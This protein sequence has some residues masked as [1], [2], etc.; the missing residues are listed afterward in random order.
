MA[1]DRIG[2]SFASPT[3]DAMDIGPRS[4]YGRAL[5]DPSTQMGVGNIGPTQADAAI[6]G[7]MLRE[8]A[9]LKR[10]PAGTDVAGSAAPEPLA[11]SGGMASIPYSPSTQKFWIGGRLVDATN[12]LEV[13]ASEPLAGRPSA[14]APSEVA[15][16]WIGLSPQAYGQYVSK[17]KTPRGF[18]ANVALGARGL[19]EQTLGGVGDILS[20]VGAPSVGEPIAKFAETTFGQTKAEQE[21]SA[22]IQQSNSMMSNIWDAVAQG[23]PSVGLSFVGGGLGALA[24]AARATRIAGAAANLGQARTIGALTGLAAVTYPS[25][26]QNFYE[27]A[28]NAKNPDGTPAYNLNDPLIGA[29]IAAAAG[30]TTLLQTFA[31]GKIAAGF[32]PFFTD[33]IKNA[34][35]QVTRSAIGRAAVGGA[36]GAAS[37]A[38]AEGVTQ[39]AQQAVFDPEFRSKL[40]ASDWKALA[41]YVIEKY[42]ENALIA[43]GAGAVLGG[44]FG[45][46]FGTKPAVGLGNKPTNLLETAGG[47]KGPAP[48]PTQMELPL[49]GPQ[50]PQLELP[51]EMPR[52]PVPPSPEPTAPAAP[53]PGQMELPLG[54]PTQLE[55][56]LTMPQ[57]DTTGLPLFEF[58]QG[59]LQTP[60]GGQIPLPLEGGRGVAPTP[61]T[62]PVTPTQL[63]LPLDMPQPGLPLEGGVARLR[64][65]QPAIGRQLQ[66]Q[67]AASLAALAARSEAAKA[68][69]YPVETPTFEEAPTVDYLKKLR[70]FYAAEQRDRVRLQ[71][72]MKASAKRELAN[73]IKAK[74]ITKAEAKRL[75]SNH[76]KAGNDL[77]KQLD[78][79]IADPTTIPVAGVTP[80]APAPAAA[81]VQPTEIPNAPQ[82]R[83]VPEGGVGQY[84]GTSGQVQGEGD[85]RNVPTQVQEGGDQTGGGN[86]PVEGGPQPEQVEP[87]TT[88]TK[89]GNVTF[90]T[91]IDPRIADTFAALWQA[92]G[93]ADTPVFF[94]VVNDENVKA[95]TRSTPEALG[96]STAQHGKF[97]T[98]LANMNRS[99]A[100]GNNTLLSDGTT[101]IF[102]KSEGTLDSRQYVRALETISHE[103]GHSVERVLLSKASNAEIA[104]IISDYNKFLTKLNVNKSV[105]NDIN[106]SIIRRLNALATMNFPATRQE[107]A[108]TAE[109]FKK[110]LA[111]AK[112]T[113][114]KDLATAL[115][116]SQ[117]AK[118]TVRGG[119][120]DTPFMQTTVKDKLDYWL[121]FNEWFADQTSKWATTQAKPLT[122]VEKF[123]KRLAD[124][125][126]RLYAAGRTAGLPEQSVSTFLDRMG[127][128]KFNE[129]IIPPPPPPG[130]GV[131]DKLVRDLEPKLSEDVVTQITP[132]ENAAA[133]AR[134]DNFIE[135]TVPAP[136][137]DMAYTI[138]YNI[139]D[140][141]LKGAYFMSFS[142]D[143]INWISPL[144]PT[145]RQYFDGIQK[146]NT[147]IEQLKREVDEVMKQTGDLGDAYKQVNQFLSD[148]TLRQAWGFQP[149]WIK[150]PVTIDPQMQAQYN[151][152]PDNAKKVVSAVFEKNYKD[153]RKMR[154][155]IEEQVRAGLTGPEYESLPQ[156]EKARLQQEAANRLK[157]LDSYLKERSGPYA[158]LS[159][160]GNYVTVAKS[161]RLRALEALPVEDR[162]A[163]HAQQVAELE[164]NPDDYI[165]I[166]SDSL[167]EA[168]RKER[169][170]K[171]QFPGMTT[172]AFQKQKFYGAI[173]APAWMAMQQVKSIIENSEEA[174]FGKKELAVINS[175]IM[176]LYVGMLAENSARRHQ[177]A[178]KGVAGFDDML[179]AFSVNGV[180]NAHFIGSMNFEPEIAG[181][182]RQ[183]SI[184]A[185]AGDGA[186]TREDRMRA[187]NEVM[188]RHVAGI[189]TQPTPLQDTL[190][191]YNSVWTLL[192]LP[193]Y[194]ILNGSQTYMLSL[195]YMAA[196]FGYGR[197]ASAIN[198]TYREM[199][200]SFAKSTGGVMPALKQF[201]SG[202]F[203][204]TKLKKPDGKAYSAEE[205]KLLEAL[206]D[207]GLLDIG[208]G[209][210]LGYWETNQTPGPN[211]SLQR[212]LQK[213]TAATRQIEVINRVS[214]GL[215]AY[216]LARADNMS[217]KAAFDY[218]AKVISD[219]QGDYSGINAPRLFN[220]FS[221]S[222]VILQ[223]RKFQLMQASLLI[224]NTHAAFAGASEDERKLGR[225]VLRNVLGQ[226]ALVTGALGLPLAG[227]VSYILAAI[228]GPP[229]EPVNEERFLRRILGNDRLA[230]FIL[231]GVPAGLGV[232][233]SSQLGLNNVF[234][235]A[236]YTDLD[237]A[238]RDAFAKSVVGLGGP[239]FGTAAS[240]ADG[241]KYYT[242]GQLYKAIE[243][244]MPNGIK[245]AMR[246]YRETFDKGVTR[247]NGDLVV[248]SE[249]FTFFD[250]FLQTLGFTTSTMK[251]VKRT[252]QDMYE[253]DKYFAERTTQIRRQYT[254][255][256]RS[257]DSAAITAARA[258]WLALQQSKKRVGLTAS[259]M[260]TLTSAP[261]QQLRREQQYRKQFKTTQDMEEAED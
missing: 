232:D 104:A 183:M 92:V 119:P 159:R 117:M 64:R 94:G 56:P 154:A 124:R 123:F 12:P 134:I 75:L 21:R 116:A 118:D 141:S 240:F 32:S 160:F 149:S 209:Y 102:L 254:E 14:P 181:A 205:I 17:L 174:G 30:G 191:R 35:A 23:V 239:L 196:K 184:D 121:G 60:P 70:A 126:K 55:L 177:L 218:A 164:A 34:G 242:E 87:V 88:G 110:A 47:P 51:M 44:A 187:Y 179:R 147:L 59:V 248:S 144:L 54:Q 158:A 171:T 45:A 26:F 40:N 249:E 202:D 261:K 153:M 150:E 66:A 96:V 168:K 173:Q 132:E 161:A 215:A 103:I 79:Y 155:S 13:A 167:G 76:I 53:M 2:L 38:F 138:A 24:G 162:D 176:D 166:F 93:M 22:L 18:G 228:F 148:S 91:N 50:G 143:L 200:Y 188:G 213:L 85:N 172:D 1:M 180:A 257:G 69:L 62:L 238:G 115:R 190:L 107:K 89:R 129:D 120:S 81:P 203:D 52:F 204:L 86:L 16:D 42:G 28:K 95:Y 207:N 109:L 241:Y 224:K 251:D 100:Y 78:S 256:K 243:A 231:N 71:Q 135:T 25:E 186:S 146:R 57:P 230:D 156:E 139:R 112:G 252:R 113:S 216:R 8:N 165:V 195:P 82:V 137:Q 208:M 3:L 198:S 4:P 37:E 170:I 125:L 212:V 31:E 15:A 136:L 197:T 222:K 226:T 199:A 41:P 33:A 223:F 244:M 11:P 127:A 227:A 10:V 140:F 189:G 9:G 237:F 29:E 225:A 201:F 98:E 97:Y 247:R 185:R 27:A 142:R 128:P 111:Q 67:Q 20:T 105:F 63:E 131:S 169:E 221:F 246:A 46:A 83:Q 114:V 253:F 236:P 73:I 101:L 260:G 152:L 6:F 259:N 234:S 219:T 233:V 7:E 145:A 255:A 43:A 229:D 39:L 49:G 80:T 65:T 258:D 68:D 250:S 77:L 217:E 48:M 61:A 19:A 192:T 108:K 178:R 245:S 58:P 72:G 211:R 99:S 122:L 90:L 214:S 157:L 163:N 182:L 5:G 206:R 220:S 84:Q 151:A 130:S 193:R 235:P 36:K 74:D 106:E 133:N 194:Y 175:F 210:D